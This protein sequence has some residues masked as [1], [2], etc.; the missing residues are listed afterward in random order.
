MIKVN[1]RLFLFFYLFCHSVLLQAQTNQNS[2]SYFP[3]TYSQQPIITFKEGFL[4]QTTYYLDGEKSSA[5]E[6]GDL[7]NS[8]ENEDF[9]FLAYQRKKGWGTALNL[10]GLAI[11]LGSITYLFTKEF[12][13]K[14]VRPWYFVT[15]GGGILQAT[16]SILIGNAERSIR[17][18]I[19]DFNAYHYSGGSNSYLRMDVSEGFLAPKIEIYEGPMLLQKDQVLS[20]LQANEQA[21]QLYEQ[22][23]KRQ[24]VGTVSHM[25]NF[26]LGIG[27]TFLAI[28]NE[29]QSSTQNDLL[30]PMTLTGIGLNIFSRNYDRRTRNLT[31]EVLHGY[32]YTF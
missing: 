3:G 21:Y 26:A 20:R 31:R 24:K 19:D 13:P 16:G 1:K 15:L 8:I 32:N 17:R 23:L 10:T 4:N 2:P 11:N 5:K 30:I 22:V 12:T 18:S 14:N 25:V 27:I 6:V 9:E 28:G 7:L 29:Q